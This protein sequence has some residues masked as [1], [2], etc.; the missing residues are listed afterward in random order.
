MTVAGLL[1][2]FTLT[3]TLFVV[4]GRRMK[5]LAVHLYPRI[6]DL[7]LAGSRED[8]NLLL[9]T[10]TEPD[11]SLAAKILGLDYLLLIG[12][13]VGGA[14]LALLLAGFASRMGWWLGRAGV[15]VAVAFVVAAGCDA[16]ENLAALLMIAL[17]KCGVGS[18]LPRVTT[19]FSIAKFGIIALA[20]SYF[21][22]LFVRGEFALIG[23]FVRFCCRLIFQ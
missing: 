21:V 15:A 6:I 18:I 13:G 22:V 23:S 16:V 12:Y 8:A 2:V 3:I 7:E 14:S 4:V 17:A 9:L 10:W 1:L 20:M 19:F 11:R 5:R